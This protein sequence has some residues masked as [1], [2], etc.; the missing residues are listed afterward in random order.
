MTYQNIYDSKDYVRSRNA[1][2]AQS[3]VEYFIT[4][5]VTDS[6]LAKVLTEIGV[7]D[8]MTGIISSFVAFAFLFQLV[9]FLLASK[10][11]RVRRTV[12]L[13][14]MVSS[15]LFSSIYLIPFLPL[16]DSAKTLIV[17]AC[18]IIAYSSN[19]FVAPV[20]FKWANYY[21]SPEERGEYSATKEIISL[22]GGMG[23]TL[24]GGFLIDFFEV[25]GILRIGFMVMA[26]ILYGLSL[27]NFSCLSRIKDWGPEVKME[28]TATVSQ[29]RKYLM[30][31]KAFR[32]LVIMTVLW[33]VVV[34]MTIGYMGVYKIK[35]L[36][37]GVG[38]IQ[39][40]NIGANMCRALVSKPIGRFSDRYS[41]A[42]GMKMAL[43][44]IAT[45]FLLNIFTTPNTWWVVILF[46]VLYSVG[47][48]GINQNSFNIV[49]SY[50]DNRY[51][52]QAMAIK[53]SI[54]G[55]CGFL[56]SLVGGWI[57]SYIQENGNTFLGMQVYG[58]Q[59][60]SCIS[61]VAVIVLIAFIHFVIERQKAMVQ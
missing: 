56:A 30:E 28:K 2:T 20:L 45:A 21:V 54:G 47:I 16:G 33:N 59:L 36:G 53:N 58:Q 49:Y 57:L 24:F 22:L 4:I 50:V 43:I 7:S 61:F 39:L 27:C 55:I 38:V 41:Y 34:Y 25:R 13:F 1:Y 8:T 14:C 46:T 6:F 19:Y 40:I 48:A 11:K 26:A 15:L 32:N 23:F 3:A 37:L 10:I 51:L 31:N 5:A 44:I 29:A 9:S 60:L 42:R 35:E 12:M 17:M 52:V 18:I